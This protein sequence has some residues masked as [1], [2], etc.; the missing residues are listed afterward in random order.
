MTRFFF[1]TICCVHLAVRAFEQMRRQGG[2]SGSRKRKSSDPGHDTSTESAEH[3]NIE[4]DAATPGDALSVEESTLVRI[5]RVLDWHALNDCLS[6]V[7]AVSTFDTRTLLDS[8]PFCKLLASIRPSV[9]GQEIP[10]VTRIYE[11]QYMRQCIGAHEQPCCMGKQCECMTIN[12]EHPF[13]GVRFVIPN[14]DVGSN[15]MCVLCLRK[16][17]TLLFY[18]TIQKGIEVH[19]TIQRHGNI[20]NQVGEYHPSVML[21]CPP[22]GP[23]ESMPLPIVAHQRNRYE[24]VLVHGVCYLKQ[25]RVGMLDFQ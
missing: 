2:S 13:V 21:I 25:L 18:R 16:M 5:S 19:T 17:T 7:P 20:C 1:G 3:V 12:K 23:V 14:T 6:S 22:N 10:L 24:V 15:G 9:K 4:A 11:E 8:I